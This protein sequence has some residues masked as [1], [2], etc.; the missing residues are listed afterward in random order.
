MYSAAHTNN[1]LN[2]RDTHNLLRRPDREI[3]YP[4]ATTGTPTICGDAQTAKSGISNNN[5]DTHYLPRCP[6]REIG[7]RA[8]GTPTI[9]SRM[10][11]DIMGN[12]QRGHPQ[13]AETPRPRNRASEIGKS[14]LV[15]QPIDRNLRFTAYQRT[16]FDEC[17]Y[18]FQQ[19]STPHPRSTRSIVI[20]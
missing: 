18:D 19:P 14:W 15:A 12:K 6:D 13:S 20:C 10:P 2:N 9:R 11:S 16:P 5:R 7:S 8:T 3:G 17:T 1:R 4:R